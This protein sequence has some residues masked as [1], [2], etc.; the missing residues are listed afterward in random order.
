M[1]IYMYVYMYYNLN[2]YLDVNVSGVV[3]MS[4]HGYRTC[5]WTFRRRKESK[6][7]VASDFSAFIRSFFNLE[8]YSGG[9][10]NRGVASVQEWR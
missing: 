5:L 1:C 2:K 10:Q 9:R 6:C 4:W 7:C 3:K 8:M